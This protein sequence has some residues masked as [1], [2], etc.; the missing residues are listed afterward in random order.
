MH[1]PGPIGGPLFDETMTE[2][3]TTTDSKGRDYPC[4]AAAVL[5]I[6]VDNDDRVLSMQRPGASEWRT[7]AGT[8]ERNEGI[9]AACL[10]ELHEE[11]GD[12]VQGEFLGAVHADVVEQ[13]PPM[14]SV[15]SVISLFRMTS[16][17]VEPGDDMAGS[18]VRWSAI[19]DLAEA[20]E[21]ID[22]PRGG[23]HLWQR[24]RLLL[25]QF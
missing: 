15:V 13:A 18:K 3:P 11:A 10:R 17:T 25:R 23:P 21:A 24:V 14:A 19:D 6:V 1:A 12:S 8:L 22:V 2:Y 7:V 4:F 5:V 16:G 20:R 9:E